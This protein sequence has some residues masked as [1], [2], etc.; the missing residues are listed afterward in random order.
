M[1]RDSELC[2][3]LPSWSPSEGR[4]LRVC[5]TASEVHHNLWSTW[6]TREP[7]S[8]IGGHP[9]PWNHMD[10]IGSLGLQQREGAPSCPQ[11][12]LPCPSNS[13]ELVSSALGSCLVPIQG[14]QEQEQQ[15]MPCGHWLTPMQP[16]PVY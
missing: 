10:S 5:I 14:C 3:H 2:P 15:K 8:P 7:F 1:V 11:E 9:P 6:F 4:K 13:S 12:G 16:F